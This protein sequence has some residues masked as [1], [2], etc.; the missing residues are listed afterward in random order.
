MA[1]QVY[2]IP[3][4]NIPQFFNITLKGV[5]YRITSRWNDSPEGG[6][7]LDID[8]ANTGTPLLYNLPL[9]TGLDI[10]EPFAYLGFGGS[11]VVFTDNNTYATPTL[12]DLGIESNLYFI[13][14]DGQ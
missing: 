13:T 6:W 9:T 12:T 2:R 3:L 5:E 4:T 10:L 14:D 11:M 7:F 8:D 1:L